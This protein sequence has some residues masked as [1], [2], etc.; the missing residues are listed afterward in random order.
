MGQQMETTW[1]SFTGVVEILVTTAQLL[2]TKRD[3]SSD[4]DHLALIYWCDRD[5]GNHGHVAAPCYGL[6]EMGQHMESTFSCMVETLVTT[7]AM[8]PETLRILPLGMAARS[9]MGNNELWLAVSTASADNLRLNGRNVELQQELS[10]SKSQHAS[11]DN[12]R[13]KGRNVELQQVL[14]ASKREVSGAS[15]ENLRL[16]VRNVELQQELSSAKREAAAALTR[17]PATG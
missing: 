5:L 11:A 14:S 17:K 7:G 10:A 9:V 13:L 8:E 6:R 16:K 3:G 12:L 1:R 2:S 15:A 4:G